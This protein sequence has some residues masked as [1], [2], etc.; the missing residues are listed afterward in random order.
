MRRVLRL[1]RGLASR[2]DV[3]I[4]CLR[5]FRKEATDKAIHRGG[6]SVGIIGAARA[7]WALAYHPD[8]ESVASWPVRRGTSAPRRPARSP[9]SCARG[10]RTVI[11]RTSTGEAR[12]TSEPTNRCP[13]RTSLTKLRR[14]R[15]TRLST[16]PSASSSRC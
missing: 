9:S 3:A 1:L 5:H 4:I 6:G 15:T 11:T 16:M 7:G 10:R 8:D 14:K 2:N 12:S 13:R